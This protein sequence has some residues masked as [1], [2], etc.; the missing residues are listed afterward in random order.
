ML[1]KTVLAAAAIATISAAALVPTTAS[2]HGFKGW[3]GGKYWGYGAGFVVR[4]AAGLQL[5]LQLHPLGSDSLRRGEG[6]RL[7]LIPSI[8]P[9]RK[10]RSRAASRGFSYCGS[11]QSCRISYRRLGRRVRGRRPDPASA[12]TSCSMC[13][14]E[15]IRAGRCWRAE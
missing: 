14:D 7:L 12:S 15:L 1:R 9:A 3:Y 8:I 13:V 11:R 2:A 10:P 5:P 4:R 6:E